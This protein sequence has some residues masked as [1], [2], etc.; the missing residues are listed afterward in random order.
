MKSRHKVF[1]LGIITGASGGS[2][3]E[4]DLS[5]FSYAW[6]FAKVTQNNTSVW[7][8]ASPEEF[9]E[10]PDWYQYGKRANFSNNN[11]FCTPIPMG[12]ATDYLVPQRIRVSSN[13]PLS[14]I[15][16]DAIKEVA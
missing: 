2:T 4:I 13:L 1:E 12:Y 15:V 7:V 5:S 10:A 11:W 14:D 9:G 6:L 16:I 3:A 8:E